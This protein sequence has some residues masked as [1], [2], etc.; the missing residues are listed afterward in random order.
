MSC[1]QFD[2]PFCRQELAAAIATDGLLPL[3]KPD[4]PAPFAA[5]L[6]ACWSVNP[7]DRPSAQ[8]MLHSLQAMQA[9]EW[10]CGADE[11]SEQTA[12][13]VGRPAHHAGS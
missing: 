3:T 5:L 11:A 9:E 7:S 1:W 13:E 4:T 6:T 12:G 8:D 2:H 10:A